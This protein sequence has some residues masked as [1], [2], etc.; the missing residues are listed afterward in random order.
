MKTSKKG[1]GRQFGFTLIEVIVA[2]AILAGGIIVVASAWSGNYLRIRKANLYNNVA[3]LLQ[4]KITELEAQYA[5]KPIE[6]IPE[7][8][9]GDFGSEL[10]R[11]RWEISSQEFEMPDLSSI[12]VNRDGGADENLLQVIQQTTQFINKSVKE[13]TVAVFVKSRKKE[14]KF[15]V[16]TYFVDYNKDLAIGGVSGGSQ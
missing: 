12:L 11:Y 5:G 13:V 8:K 15:E 16:N 7:E 10:P 14:I 6:E 3:I 1:N 9:K 2:V 4:Q